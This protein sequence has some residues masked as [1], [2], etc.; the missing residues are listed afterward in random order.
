MN[1]YQ[2]QWNI[3]EKAWKVQRLAHALLFVGPL[4]CDLGAFTQKVAQLLLC[5]KQNNQADCMCNDCLML[6]NNQ[7]PDLQWIKAENTF[8]SIK[9][10]QIRELQIN[11]YLTPQRAKCRLVVLEGA[12]RM[13]TASANALLK[14]LEE[15][16]AHSV[17][18]L[19]AQQLGTVLPTILSR[20]Q[21]IRFASATNVT[22]E[23][24]LQL[25]AY[26]PPDSE[27]AAIIQQAEGLLDTLIALIQGKEHPCA[28]AAQ[29]AKFEFNTLFW[30][31]YLVF[32]QC[33]YLQFTKSK[34]SG[35]AA[36]QL[37]QLAASLD[38]VLIFSQLDAINGILKKLSQNINS[39]QT[40]VLEHFLFLCQEG[41]SLIPQRA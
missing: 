11:A 22:E 8:G 36:A 33:N 12:D 1:T 35:I 24:L 6:V 2:Q 5:S 32:A 9:I 25:G 26:Y 13:N 29:W 41:S 40:L 27:R 30:F 20:C 15:P 21:L 7:H 16:A 28:V 10:D 38:P 14:I 4:H 17:F 19:L 39:N 31:L 18:I 3:I 34:P 23:N 37:Q